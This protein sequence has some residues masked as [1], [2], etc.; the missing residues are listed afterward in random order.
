MKCATADGSRRTPGFSD[1]KVKYGAAYRYRIRGVLRWVR[2]HGIGPLGKDPTTADAP[3]ATINT[4]TPDDASFFAS[5]WGQEWASA[6]VIDTSP[7]PPP[8]QFQVRPMSRDKAIEITFC[9]PYNPQQDICK[10]TLWR[11]LQDELGNDVT[12]WVQIQEDDAQFRQGT[13]HVYGAEQQHQQDDLT[14]TK[15][16]MNQTDTVE[17]FVEF[18][19]LNARFVDTD[20]G[21]FGQD[22]NYRYVYAAM[23]HTRHG[24]DSTLSD[25]LAARLNPNWSKDGEFPL[26]FVSCAGVDKDFDTG[27]F[28]T[29]PER[30]LRSEVIAVPTIT[31][32]EKVPAMITFSG[33]TRLAQNPIQGSSYVA[34]IESLDTGQRIDV[35][36]VVNVKNMPEKN[37]TQDVT[38]LVPS[39]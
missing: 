23:C 37:S 13:R 28:S 21:Y 2:I 16:N 9:L 10:M 22:N 38:A 6:M 18:A 4:L 29:Y 39:T 14:G 35:P 8:H 7:P 11:K 19:P 27:I 12:D 31:A 5:E 1:T 3:G 34:R 33:Q 15:F 17:T 20:V 24:E 36:V 30:R 32:T 25:Q 26:D